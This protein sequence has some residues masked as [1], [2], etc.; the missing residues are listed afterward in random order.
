MRK[1]RLAI[2]G[3]GRSGRGI[4]G[5][6]YTLPENKYVEV[7]A[8]VDL[9]EHRRAYAERYGCKDVYA[10]YKEL[11]ARKD[12]DV[13]INASFSCDHY[14]VTKDLLLHGFNV[15]VE[16]PMAVTYKQASELIAIAKQKG[17]KLTV[18]QQTLMS[19][20]FLKLKEI[21]DSGI[22]GKPLQVNLRYNGFNRR[23]DWQTLQSWGGGDLYNTG[24]HGIGQAL[25]L[26]GWDPQYKVSFSSL[27]RANIAGD[28]D[29]YAKVI[30]TAPNKPVIDLEVSNV[31]PFENTLYTVFGT[32]GGARIH[33]M[34]YE[35]KYIKEEELP[36]LKPI[37][38]T[39]EKEDGSPAYCSEKL[40]WYTE[41]G[42]IDGRDWEE[43][44]ERFY[45][46]LYEG[47]MDIAPF[48]V[49][50][51]MGAEVVRVLEKVTVDNPFP[52]QYPLYNEHNDKF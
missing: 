4:H 31:F 51:E 36:K 44:L 23:Y 11:Y 46:M 6:F 2:I 15:I 38:K 1:L 42:K 9:L 17:V 33:A 48:K 8:V 5:F 24:P 37:E 22:I 21:I 25:D 39:L 47:L 13:V 28:G 43:V 10:D 20:Q 3:Q 27:K 30:L 49:T 32:K 40:N 16:K 12:I 52:V 7:V 14:P 19:S 18:F 34:N 26:L 41:T 50:A 45:K 29:D 35:I